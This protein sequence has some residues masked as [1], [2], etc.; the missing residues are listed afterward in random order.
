MPSARPQP[1]IARQAAAEFLGTLLLVCTVVGSGIM[2]QRL[3]GD[4]AVALLCNT[5][6]TAAILFVLIVAFASVSGARFNPCVALIAWLEKGLTFRQTLFHVGVQMGGAVGGVWLA[7][8]MFAEP[9][10]ALGAKMRNGPSQLLS[11]AVATFGLIFVIR[12]TA[13]RNTETLAAS[14]ALYIG[15][16]YWFT[17]STSFANPAVTFARALTPTFSGIR[18]SDA[19]LFIVAQFVGALA[20]WCLSRWMYRTQPN[21]L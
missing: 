4:G 8:A 16:A 10:F 9:I 14:V 15:A 13:G 21:A 3:A 19:V 1:D 20:A 12:A 7:H 11:E 17:A 6:A 18:P 5:V 2:A